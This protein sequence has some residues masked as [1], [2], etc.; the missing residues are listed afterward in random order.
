MVSLK[1]ET[2]IFPEETE[3]TVTEEL[4]EMPV[5][6]SEI[7]IEDYLSTDIDITLRTR[8]TVKMTF[9]KAGSKNFIIPDLTEP[10]EGT[11]KLDPDTPVIEL[12]E[13]PID[14]AK[15]LIQQYVRENE[16]CRTS[17]IIIELALDPDL[18]IEA[19]HQLDSEEL[20]ESEDIDT[21]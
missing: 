21:E 1:S 3:K 16:G 12:R 8:A 13:L 10:L 4:I 11:I 7:E 2:I 14:E 19:I 15:K 20:L 9:N 18:V 6:I 17:Q 5:T